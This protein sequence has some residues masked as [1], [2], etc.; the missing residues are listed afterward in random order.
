VRAAPTTLLAAY[1]IPRVTNEIRIAQMTMMI[2]D[3]LTPKPPAE[4]SGIMTMLCQIIG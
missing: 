4:G 2:A 1:E 3:D